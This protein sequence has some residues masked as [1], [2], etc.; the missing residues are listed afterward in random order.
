MKEEVH[1]LLSPSAAARWVACPGSVALTA[2]MERASSAYAVEGTWAHRLAEL[3]LL[4]EEGFSEAEV[5]EVCDAGINPDDL[6]E[7]VQVYVDYVRS[8]PGVLMV[9]RKLPLQDITGEEGARGTAD[10]VIAGDDVLHI[11]DLKFG[12]GEKIEAR[13]NLQLAIYAQAALNEY[14]YMGDFERV[15]LH[16]IQPR[17]HNIDDWEISVE[18][19]WDLIRLVKASAVAALAGE[20]QDPALPM[21][22]PSRK[23]CRWCPARGKCPHLASYCLTAAGFEDGLLTAGSPL[24]DSASLGHILEK[25]DLIAKWSDAVREVA[26]AEF[27]EGRDVPGFKLVE[28]REGP[29]KWSDDKQAEKLLKA[30]KIPADLRYVKK[31]ITPTQAEKLYK[32][33]SFSDEQWA[34]LQGVVTRAPGK[35]ELVPASDPR[36]AYSCGTSAEDYPD[37]TLGN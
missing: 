2:D 13:D 19:L 22:C 4:G 36:P 30:W 24:L 28:G 8:I 6:K 17:L 9:E 37:E 20:S 34:E 10:A 15:H 26:R 35:L 16:I 21:F 1:A 33:H 18:A 14:G 11:C 32:A 23:A 25:L 27:M 31:V 12:I 7:P 5:A 3:L 29:R